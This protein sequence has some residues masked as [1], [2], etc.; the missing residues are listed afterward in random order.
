MMPRSDQDAFEPVSFQV[1]VNLKPSELNT[2]LFKTIDHRIYEKTSGKCVKKVGYV[3]PG[4]IQV[5]AKQLGKA[6]GY[7]FSGN[8]TYRVQVNALATHPIPGQE[9]TCLVVKKNDS[10]LVAKNFMFP[11]QLYVPKL[12]NNQ[13]GNSLIDRVETNSYI[14]VRFLDSILKAPNKNTP[15][16]EYWV[17]C[18]IIDDKSSSDNLYDIRLHVLPSISSLPEIV[19]IRPF[20]PSNILDVRDY[21]SNYKYNM[22]Q[23]EKNSIGTMSQT[24]VSS[25]GDFTEIDD[26]L[27]FKSMR[28]TKQKY[29]LLVI[30]ERRG[31]IFECEILRNSNMAQLQNEKQITIRADLNKD[32]AYLVA[33]D[34]KQQ[35]DKCWTL[36]SYQFLD[37]W[38]L[39]VKYVV[40][41]YE[42]IKPPK[43]YVNQL[44]TLMH[45]IKPAKVDIS[46][47][48]RAYFKMFEMFD[49]IIPS[50]DCATVTVACI[51][52]SPGG[53]I[54][55]FLDRRPEEAEDF[56]SAISIRI[57]GQT[58]SVWSKIT[59]VISEKVEL[60]DI[61]IH[62]EVI[63]SNHR[64]VNRPFVQLLGNDGD[65][66]NILVKYNRD[67]F[68]SIFERG[69]K[70]M[71]VTAD[72]GFDTKNTDM[73]DLE[74]IETQ[75]LLVAEI[76]MALKIQAP[77]GNFVI[78]VFD[79][80]TYASVDLLSMLSYCY[81]NV[82]MTKPL[83]SR[84]ASS[85]KYIICRGYSSDSEKTNLVI[86]ILTRY[87]ETPHATDRFFAAS[88]EEMTES[89]KEYNAL[90]MTQQSNFILRG[91][92]YIELYCADKIRSREY[93]R[94]VLE[95]QVSNRDKFFQD[96]SPPFAS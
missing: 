83:T 56:I 75:Q 21:L 23:A 8:I 58:D 47:I 36:N 27:I 78:K 93:V 14:T 12:P 50:T 9:M 37:A 13:E 48:S 2:D 72:G 59:G 67:R 68:C 33:F 5:G 22:L 80:V 63:L 19:S 69:N 3:K 73:V 76:L 61:T 53:F 89:M 90:F 66:G 74:E 1:K 24:Y 4:S 86:Q 60:N 7:D 11:Y 70:A 95:Q 87:L 43:M 81:D 42:M 85:E 55:A 71:L 54:Q 35:R 57:Q 32:L 46:P 45:K 62:D 6:E 49:S 79:T 39:H 40:N 84:N 25:L 88:N 51:A 16:A 52:E 77:G 20:D 64:A 29:V 82:Y 96:F 31:D 17:I 30:K 91:K 38:S 18:E 41:P 10:G 94:T 28:G 65:S 26:D 44:R 15:N 92:E 34:L